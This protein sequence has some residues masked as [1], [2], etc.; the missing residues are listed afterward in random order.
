MSSP[1]MAEFAMLRVSVLVDLVL[2]LSFQI[3]AC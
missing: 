1:A 3:R 2:L